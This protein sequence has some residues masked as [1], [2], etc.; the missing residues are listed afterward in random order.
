[1]QIHLLILSTFLAT[2]LNALQVQQRDLTEKIF[3]LKSSPL[4]TSPEIVSLI[5]VLSDISLTN[6]ELKI[7]NISDLIATA[8]N[9]LLQLIQNRAE[10]KNQRSRI[11][12]LD[13]NNRAEKKLAKKKLAEARFK[14]RE[15][16]NVFKEAEN[17]FE[18]SNNAAQFSK[19]Q[20]ADV[21]ANLNKIIPDFL[22]LEAFIKEN[23]DQLSKAEVSFMRTGCLVFGWDEDKA[24]LEL[25]NLKQ[26]IEKY[27]EMTS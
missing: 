23:E 11:Q 22:M 21:K 7:F 26:L 20:L 9:S 24:Q 27:K 2:R 15:A 1:M 5:R 18:I 14:L 6:E 13:R 19:K 25:Y 4:S 17:A 12:V 3:R 8:K 16:E 10:L